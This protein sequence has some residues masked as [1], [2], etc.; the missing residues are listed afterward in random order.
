MRSKNRKGSGGVIFV[1]FS[2]F[3]F[4]SLLKSQRLNFPTFSFCDKKKETQILLPSFIFV[5]L[6]VIANYFSI[7]LICQMPLSCMIVKRKWKEAYILCVYKYFQ[8]L[9]FSTFISVVHDWAWLYTVHNRLFKFISLFLYDKKNHFQMLKVASTTVYRTNDIFNTQTAT[10][11]A[12][13]HPLI[14]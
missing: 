9:I 10:G 6:P 1:S 3:F 2:C 4:G 12:C 5:T 11:E 7:N 13:C 14:N 8:S